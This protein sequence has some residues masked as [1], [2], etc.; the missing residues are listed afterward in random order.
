VLTGDGATGRLMDDD[1]V[2]HRVPGI[3]AYLG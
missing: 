1:G 3:D 2:V